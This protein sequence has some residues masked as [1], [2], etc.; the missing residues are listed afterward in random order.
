M[1]RR[2]TG[3]ICARCGSDSWTVRGHR[4]CLDCRLDEAAD[5]HW[6][7]LLAVSLAGIFVTALVIGALAAAGCSAPRRAPFRAPFRELAP[8]TSTCG[9]S[10]GQHCGCEARAC[11]RPCSSCCKTIP[12]ERVDGPPTCTR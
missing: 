6:S 3:P 2:A 11:Q 5:R 12:C 8:V 4:L 7:R 9:P 10:D 1:T